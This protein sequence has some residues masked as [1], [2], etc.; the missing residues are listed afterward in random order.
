MNSAKA[1]EYPNL[2]TIQKEQKTRDPAGQTVVQWVDL[3]VN[4]KHWA[5]IAHKSGL[6]TI[7]AD[8]LTSVVQASIRLRGYRVD[9][10]ASMRIMFGAVAYQVKAV[11]P[12]HVKR[13]FVDLA[14]ETEVERG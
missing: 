13:Q 7:K 10:D 5:N 1:G 4:A 9:L 8:G 11:M 12:D 3:P 6:E 14:C 2:V